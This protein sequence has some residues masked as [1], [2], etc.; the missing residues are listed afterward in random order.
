ML[1]II[2]RF[3]TNLNKNIISKY[4]YFLIDLDNTVYDENEY[5]FEAYENISQYL[6]KLTLAEASIINE[7]LVTNFLNEGRSNLFDKL[8]N[9]FN[10]NSEIISELLTI[11]R[12][13]SPKKK[14]ELF[15]EAYRFMDSIISA[16]KEIFIVTNGNVIQQR[17]K[18]NNINWRNLDSKIRFLF[19]NEFKPKPSID[20][21]LQLKEL[22]GIDNNNCVMIGD[23]EVDLNY[24][25]NCQIAFFY[26]NEIFN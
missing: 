25:K 2:T 15:P 24:A 14:I 12:T 19:A 7:Y 22:H 26:F 11:L 8:L 20:S 17:N 5:L 18:V 13:F 1:D 6:E 21:F 4:S 9:H 3:I 23:S 16:N 10:L